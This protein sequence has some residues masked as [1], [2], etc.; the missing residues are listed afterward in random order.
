MMD[1]TQIE[2]VNGCNLK[3]FYCVVGDKIQIM[4]LELAK[5]LVDASSQ[6]KT[7][8][9][10]GY[11]EPALY[12]YMAEL[13]DYARKSGKFGKI[14]TITNGKKIFDYNLFDI[15]QISCDSV[16][17]TGSGKYLKLFEDKLKTIDRSKVKLY[18]RLLDYGQNFDGVKEYCRQH[19]IQLVFNPL[20]QN[21]I[22]GDQYER[23]ASKIIHPTHCSFSKSFEGF[24]IDGS[25]TPCCYFRQIDYGTY[26]TR[27]A[28]NKRISDGDLPAS[29]VN[30]NFLA[31]ATQ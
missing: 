19:N 21:S 22:H 13:V 7:L 27:D 11:G 1:R 23:M 17:D 15:V 9:L 6:S 2:I 12:P 4:P 30:C 3:C 8:W 29:C 5:T 26:T 16:E 10:Q 28:L 25:R 18:F 14:C 31:G 24:G 20:E